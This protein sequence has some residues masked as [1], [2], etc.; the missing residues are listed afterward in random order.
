MLKIGLT[1]G[2]GSG[3]SVV[4]RI[5]SILGIPVFDADREAKKI[6]ETDPAVRA[7]LIDEFG[8]GTYDGNKLNRAYLAGRVFEDAERLEK[9]NALVHPVTISAAE[10]WMKAQTT[11]YVVKEAALLFETGSAHNLDYIVG[12]FAPEPVRIQRV[13]E[14]DRLTREEIKAR[15]SRQVQDDIKMKLCD[16]VLINHEQQLLIPQVMELH[17]KFVSNEKCKM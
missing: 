6:M 4:A 1:G 13:M 12:V 9:L 7:A 15:M 16:Y 3:K 5:F 2:I 17:R 14:R 8:V 10:A 11:P